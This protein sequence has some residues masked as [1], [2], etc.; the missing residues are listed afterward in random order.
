MLTDRALTG[1]PTPDGKGKSANLVGGKFTDW[2]KADITEALDSGFTPSG[3]ALGSA[4]AAVVRNT[5]E[6]RPADREAIAV[7]LK[8]LAPPK[9]ASAR[10]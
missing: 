8:S 7:Y 5:A 4:M 6:L 2:T 9:A 3:D 10:P 1:A